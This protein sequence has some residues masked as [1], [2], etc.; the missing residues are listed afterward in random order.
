MMNVAA[1]IICF[2]SPGNNSHGQNAYKNLLFLLFFRPTLYTH[3]R[4]LYSTINI[5]CSLSGP[6]C[7]HE[8]R[9]ILDGREGAI[10]VSVTLLGSLCA[11]SVIVQ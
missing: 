3:I 1:Q 8:N 5:T 10:T 2:M 4:T 6:M 7:C 9:E 11:K